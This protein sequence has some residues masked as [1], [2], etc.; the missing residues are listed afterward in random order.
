[1]QPATINCDNPGA[2][3]VP[4]GETALVYKV[5][6]VYTA[7]QGDKLQPSSHVLREARYEIQCPRCG[8]RTQTELFG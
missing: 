7:A 3:G 4:C 8:L 6:Y 2:H 1:M 5:H